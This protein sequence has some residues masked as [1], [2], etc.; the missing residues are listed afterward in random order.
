MRGVKHESV[1][2]PMHPERL[3]PI[4]EPANTQGTRQRVLGN[5]VELKEGRGA[6]LAHSP[7]GDEAL[8]VRRARARERRLQVGGLCERWKHNARC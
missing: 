6:A 2:V 5:W 3:T 1:R 4:F 8:D 7:I